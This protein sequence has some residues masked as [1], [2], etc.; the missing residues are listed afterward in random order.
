M[1][2]K[3]IKKIFHI[4]LDALYGKDE[5]AHFFYM[6]IEHYLGLERFVLALDPNIVVSKDEEKLLF[7]GLS[8]LKLERPIQY[9]LG[10]T[11]FMDLEL[12]VDENVLIPRPET[13]GLVRWIL[14]DQA[15][16]KEPIRILDIGTGS[17]CIAIALAKNLPNAVVVASDISGSA[18]KVAEINARMHEVDIIFLKAD[19]K[20]MQVEKGDYSVIVSNPPYVLE[21]EKAVIRNHVKNREPAGA[22]FVPDETPLLYFEYILQ[23]AKKGLQ[24]GGTLYLEIN[25][26]LGKDMILLLE[27][28]KFSEIELRKDLFGKDRMVKAKWNTE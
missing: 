14:T 13:E 15:N 10:N 2:L 21:R 18:L 17:G 4:E 8:Q 20:S 22:L 5:V 27:D 1:L 19:M 16:V 26:D 7:E 23:V 12:K 9:I 25:Q 3:E 6:L 11:L 24:P 28:Q